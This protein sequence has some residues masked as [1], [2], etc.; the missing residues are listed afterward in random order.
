[1]ENGQLGHE[2]RLIEPRLAQVPCKTKRIEHKDPHVRER[3]RPLSEYC[4]PVSRAACARHIRGPLR[5]PCYAQGRHES[6]SHPASG[7][8]DMRLVLDTDAGEQDE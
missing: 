3:Y 5:N 1:M 6:L 8:I 7:R 2:R 4:C